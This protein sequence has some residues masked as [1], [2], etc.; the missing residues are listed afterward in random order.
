MTWSGGK[1]KRK[2][3]TFPV[4]PRFGTEACYLTSTDKR[5]KYLTAGSGK[6]KIKAG[7]SARR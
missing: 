1:R 3:R 4:P 7:I 5:D 2:A 6:H